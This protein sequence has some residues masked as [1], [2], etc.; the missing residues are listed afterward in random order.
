MEPNTPL[1]TLI[2]SRICHDMA[3]P[4]GAIGNGLELLELSGAM[5]GPEGQLITQSLNAAR[6]RLELF[7]LLYGREKAGQ[8]HD[9]ARLD[10]ITTS[11]NSDSRLQVRI[12][13]D[14]PQNHARVQILFLTLQCIET[15]LPMGGRVTAQVDGAQINI[16][17]TGRK[18]TPDPALWGA[19]AQTDH[20]PDVHEPAKV[21][22]SLLWQKLVGAAATI[23]WHTDEENLEAEITF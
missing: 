10:Q 14:Q 1:S 21:Q 20:A 17:A 22:F 8:S 7:R 3:N 19:L 11:W 2:A 15:S 4:L 6:A 13:V 18:I 12:N 9:Q 23:R 5:S 16:T